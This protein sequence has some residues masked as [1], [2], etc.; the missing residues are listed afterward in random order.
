MW[1]IY[2]ID[3]YPHMPGL[4]KATGTYINKKLSIGDLCVCFCFFFLPPTKFIVALYHAHNF[5]KDA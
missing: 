1:I 4:L 2:F 3:F 5:Y